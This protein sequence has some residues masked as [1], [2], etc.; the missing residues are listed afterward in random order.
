PGGVHLRDAAAWRP[1]SRRRSAVAGRAVA[2]LQPPADAR[3]DCGRACV[4]AVPSRGDAAAGGRLDVGDEP[5]GPFSSRG[6]LRTASAARSRGPE[7]RNH[8]AIA[9]SV[10]SG[11]VVLP[12][13]SL[14]PVFRWRGCYAIWWAVW[15]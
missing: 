9:G 7:R 1:E 10:A 11:G 8:A 5:R 4:P 3:T 12:V 14:P 6:G 13:G 15:R 2:V